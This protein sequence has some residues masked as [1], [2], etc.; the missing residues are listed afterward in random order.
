MLNLI[1]KSRGTKT[2]GI[3]VTYH[4]ETGAK[5]ATCPPS[6]P[7]MPDNVAAA[8]AFDFEYAESVSVAVPPAGYAFTYTH[9]A[10]DLYVDLYRPGRTVIN[11]SAGSVREAA[12][13]HKNG[14]PTVMDIAPTA[15]PRFTFA[16]VDFRACP[17]PLAKHINCSNCGGSRAP[18]CAQVDRSWVVTFPWHGPPAVLAKAVATGAPICYGADGRVGMQ[19]GAMA[20]GPVKHSES[21][22][23]PWAA[24]LRPGSRLRH[25]VVG[26]LGESDRAW[27]AAVESQVAAA[28][29]ARTD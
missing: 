4:Y 19:W 16:G 1:A 23:E 27:T 8:V 18:I 15:P 5:F 7:L 13:R 28:L 2:K 3:A 21:D 6:C 11:S 24:Q 17:A 9:F 29:A 20:A 12:R 22:L 25:H 10:P 26:D 14:I